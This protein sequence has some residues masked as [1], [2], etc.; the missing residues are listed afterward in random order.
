MDE[1]TLNGMH[2]FI[3]LTKDGCEW[4]GDVFSDKWSECLFILDGDTYV[5]D[6]VKRTLAAYEESV[7]YRWEGDNAIWIA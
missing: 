6:R 4:Q 1:R 3:S 2:L 5:L 7:D